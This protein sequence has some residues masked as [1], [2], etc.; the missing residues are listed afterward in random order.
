VIMG[1]VKREWQETGEILRYFGKGKGAVEQGCNKWGRWF[2][3]NLTLKRERS[4]MK[5]YAE[6]SETRC[7]GDIAS[8]DGSGDRGNRHIQD[9]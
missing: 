7:S 1:R 6:T 8:C 3:Y 4:S 2:K 9:G 5:A